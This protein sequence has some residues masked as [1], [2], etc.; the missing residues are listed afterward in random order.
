MPEIKHN[1]TGGKMNK[2]VDQRLVP[3]GEYRDAMNIQVSTSEGSD[4][5]TVQNILGN[6]H[7]CIDGSLDSITNNSTTVG[8]VTDEK[9]DSLYWFISGGQPQPGPN[10]TM[11]DSIWR[12]TSN[13]NCKPVF[14]DNY[15]ISLTNPFDDTF[16]SS[17]LTNITSSVF[18]EIE[19]GWTVVGVTN[20]GV[21]SNTATISSFNTAPYIPFDFGYTPTTN[22][23]NIVSG[24]AVN[25]MID[26]ASGISFVM[27]QDINGN[28]SQSTINEVYLHGWSGGSVNQL[29]GDTI[30]IPAY[31]GNTYTI[32]AASTVSLT[33]LNGLGEQAVKLILDTNTVLFSNPT[34][35]PSV[36]AELTSG[37]GLVGSHNG[38]SISAL[39][40]S[41][42]QVTTNIAN[43]EIIF[44]T[45][46]GVPQTTGGPIQFAY[47]VTNT[48]VGSVVSISGITGGIQLSDFCVQSINTS[49]NS[50]VLEDC[51][52]G[53][54][55][56][57]GF[58]VGGLSYGVPQTTGGS[59]QFAVS[60]LVE[61]DQPLNLQG[62]YQSLYFQGPRTLNFNANTLITGIDVVDGMLFWTDNKT[63]PKKINI[64]RSI[65]GTYS[66]GLQHTRVINSDQGLSIGSNVMAR[67]KHI[68]VIRKSPIKS[69][70]L[71]LSDGRDPSLNYSA[72][73]I[74]SDNPINT[75]IISSSNP[76]TTTDFSGLLIEDTIQVSFPY[77]YDINS[78][79][80]VAWAPGDYLLLKEE[81]NSTDLPST[82]LTN[83]TIRG[84]ILNVQNGNNFDSSNGIVV[85]TIE[86]VGLNGVPPEPAAGQTMMFVADLE[87]SDTRIFQDK[88]PRFSYR[89]KYIDGEYSTFAPWSEPAFIPTSF[90]YDPKKGWNTGM[91]NNL[92]SVKLKGFNTSTYADITSI[93]IL[94]K[95]DS[96]PNVYLVQTI[97]PIDIISS[98]Q[99]DRPWFLNEYIVNSENIK[100]VIP[101]GQLLRAWDG[102]P[103]KAL[104]QSISG[105]RV[106]YGNYEQ[107][108]DLLIG[109]EI[110]TPDFNNSLVAWAPSTAGSPQKSIKSLRDYKLG[111]VFTDKYGR[112]TPVLIGENG[113]FSVKKIE[114]KNYNRLT[115]SLSG[116]PPSEMAYY[117]FYIKETSS[118][119]YNVPMDRWYSAEDGN[120]WLSMPSADRNKIDLDTFL[121]FKKGESGDKNVIENST[122]YK[123]LDIDN[124]APKWIKT[125]KI[126]IGSAKH[127][128][129]ANSCLFGFANDTTNLAPKVGEISF[130]LNYDGPSEFANLPFKTSTL[131]SLQNVEEQLYIQ[132]V[133]G[134]DY[135]SQ[136]AINEITSDFDASLTAVSNYFISLT[137][138]LDN[139]IN[140]IFDNPAFSSAIK[141]DVRVVFTK[142]VI[143]NT[144]NFDGR[145]F[146]K[147][148]NDGKIQSMVSDSTQGINYQVKVSMPVY[149]KSGGDS[150]GDY[151]IH[152]HAYTRSG[153]NYVAKDWCGSV[154]G[155][156]GNFTWGGYGVSTSCSQYKGA[157]DNPGGYNYNRLA[158]RKSFTRDLGGETM[159]SLG[160]SGE[161]SASGVFFI[162]TGKRTWKKRNTVGCNDDTL[163]WADNNNMNA[164]SPACNNLDSYSG[165]GAG[166]IDPFPGIHPGG[167]GSYINIGFS[168]IKAPGSSSLRSLFHGG[169]GSGGTGNYHLHDSISS[170]FGVGTTNDSHN[171]PAT[172]TFVEGF[173]AGSKFKWKEDPTETIYTIV[174]Q[175]DCSY[176]VHFAR[177]SDGYCMHGTA[178]IGDPSTYTKNWD[179]KTDKPIVWNPS[180]DSGIFIDGGLHLGD[181]TGSA[182]HVRNVTTDGG[183]TLTLADASGIQVGMA[184]RHANIPLECNVV[185]VAGNS[186]GISVQSTSSVTGEDLSFG[187]IIRVKGGLINGIDVGGVVGT[188]PQENYLLVD[189]ISTQC[190]NGNS[191]KPMYDLHVGMAL[192]FCNGTLSDN[193][194]GLAI[195]SIGEKDSN[196]N[197]R[198]DLGGMYKP[199]IG[200]EVCP[201]FSS[202]SG[203]ELNKA[204]AVKQAV[205][206]GAS[207]FSEANTDYSLQNHPMAIENGL[208]GSIVAV[209]YTLQFLQEY[210]TYSDGNVMPENPFIW[211][212]KPKNDE[213]VDVYYE[214]S[215]RYSIE[216]N[217]STISQTIPLQS[218]VASVLNEGGMDLMQPLVI[219]VGGP[220]GDEITIQTSIINGIPGAWVGPGSSPTGVNPIVV[221]S[222]LIITKPN[223]ESF[224]VVVEEIMNQTAFGTGYLSNKFRLQKNLYGSEHTLNWHNCYSFGNGVESNRSK[225]VYNASFM[226]NGVKVSSVFEEYAKE[227]RYSGLVYS[228]IYN[229]T[230]GI[231]NLNQFSYAEKITKDIN[232]IYGSI[233]KLHSG[234]GQGGDLVT[235][236]EDR[237]LKI[238]ANKDALF[239]ADGNTNVTSTNNV[240]GQAIPYS[241]EYGISKNPES[242]ASE[243]Y[244]IYFTDKVRGTVMRLSMDGL[245]P[246]SNH[247][248]K[249]WFRDRL[250]LGDKLIGSYDDR[251][252]EYNI[253]IKG[254]TIAKTVTFKEDVK[255]WVSFK[256]FTPENAISC[257]NEYYTFKDGNIWKHH[258]E[259]V[260]RNT[261]YNESLVPSSV[262][263]IFNEV[264]G[265]VKSFKTVNYEG[266]QAK[267]TSKD[268]NNLT[269]MDG[270]YF[271][272]VEEK[273]WHVTNVIT[274][275]EQGGITEFIKKEGKWFGYVTGNDVTISSAGNISGNYDTEDSSI[276]GIGRTSNTTTSIVY[277]CMDDTM[278]NYNDAVTND[279]GSCINF[280]HGCMDPDA[281]NFQL[282]ANTDDGSCY[283]LG[284]TTGPLADQEQFGGS[285]NYD[286]NA[287]VDDG[288]CIAAIWG[289]TILGYFNSNP[290][291]NMP[292]NYC[293]PINLGCTDSSA[294]NYVALVDEMTDVNTDDGSCE[295]LG[296]TDPIATNYNFTSSSPIVDG[297][298][299]NLTYLNGT[300][301]DDGSCTYIGGCTDALACNFDATATQ[302]NGL[303]YFCADD[304]ADNYDAVVPF[305]DYTCLGACTYCN[306]VASVTITNQTTSDAGMSNGTVTIEWPASTSSSVTSYEV[307]NWNYTI[308]ETITSSGNPTETLTITGLEAGTYNIY[309]KTICTTSAGNTLTAG[310]HLPGGNIGTG[311]HFGTTVSTTI[312]STPIPGC[313]DG[314]GANNNVGGTWGAC[315]YD[316]SATV[317]DGSCEYT[318][319]TGCND[320]AYVEY[321]GDCWDAVNQVNGPEGSNYGPWVADTIPTSCLTPI[322]YGCTDSTAF[323]YD[324]N[325]TTDDGSCVAIVLGCTDDTLNNDGSYAASN[326]NVLANTDDGS[327]NPYNC[328]YDLNI[329][330][331]SNGASF[332]FKVLNFTTPYSFADITRTATI[333]GTTIPSFTSNSNVYQGTDNIG[334]RF[335]E[336]IAGYI[337]AGDTSITV[338]FNVT[339]TDG[340]CNVDATTK[341]FTIGC[342]DATADN[343]GSFDITDNTQCT[344][345]GCMDATACN[346]NVLATTSNPGDPCLF[347]GDVNALNYDGASCNAGCVYSGCTD[348][349]PS[350]MNSLVLAASNFDPNTTVS[351]GT[352]NDN[353]CCTYHDDQ[354]VVANLIGSTNFWM[355]RVAYE[356]GSTGYTEAVMSSYVL[357]QSPGL[358]L[359]MT[360]QFPVSNM[361]SSL[362]DR[363]ATILIPSVWESY[364][365]NNNLRVTLSADFNGAC[366]ND[367]LSDQLPTGSTGFRTFNF[368]V[369]C[370]DDNTAINYDP[371]VDLGMASTCIAANPGCMDSTATNYDADFNQDCTELGS[372]NPNDCCC[373]T[374]D[375]PS[376]DATNPVV[377]NT[378][379]SL[380]SPTHA[381]QITFNF[382]AVNTAVSYNIV[383]KL[384]ASST[385]VGYGVVPTSINNGIA[386]Y[387][388]NS[389][390]PAGSPWFQDGTT[391]AFAVL[392]NCEN[393]DGDSCGTAGSGYISVELNSNI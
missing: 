6:Q 187:F 257:A 207:N 41:S 211:E 32:N 206:N 287:T 169:Y 334:R 360:N 204:L 186:V 181:A 140:I 228:G 301:I 341:I 148:E 48:T 83:W 325:A 279:D 329:S 180:S 277:G 209:G 97:S 254:N 125:K 16:N 131:A 311:P 168:G 146:V 149:E 309:V 383:I 213:G 371:S 21:Y 233:Q 199:L 316:A 345:S 281:D 289:C 132:F 20:D 194:Y 130:S 318:T 104:A 127:N 8:S 137:K 362:G 274:N 344:Y 24:V 315:N 349:T 331:S 237:V 55:A 389:P 248:M 217:P 143:Q 348:T 22:T 293:I 307:Y 72:I 49:N 205:M 147:I 184:V 200:F 375:A 335:F 292:S 291:A 120:I 357:G 232:P 286:S 260:D 103:K 312:T 98:G 73:T 253:T 172:K 338:D 121:Y 110:Y 86:I 76:A 385:F 246:I 346:Y 191:L 36:T 182:D 365:Y 214:I 366:D 314:T 112:E 244:R 96:S 370:K 15:G 196:G 154:T 87:Y 262:E 223:G 249:D 339:T 222:T 210:D 141:E 347:C 263:V 47:D 118:E 29:V 94:Y 38:S 340:N 285:I 332:V 102:V 306:D 109:G 337:T 355:V 372:T 11:R 34:L 374:C 156:C 288:S 258:N 115:A 33:Y 343:Y 167:G 275:L 303:C 40:T 378:W 113:G 152:A 95:D 77:D 256:S 70:S 56:L 160:G 75:S 202:T 170:F 164:F 240:L 25:P 65:D 299:G 134:N 106:I 297:P 197:Y 30:E 82:P 92:Q 212:T 216:L 252:D 321:C 176:D 267:V 350:T 392:A 123:V 295:Y 59:I 183:L 328:P 326:Y 234:W 99:V 393:E 308:L 105:N 177:H 269:L 31:S 388:Y 116:V 387:V 327:C 108:Y 57:Q 319:C 100:G 117:K 333:N 218:R 266:S 305:T 250:K 28:F 27:S 81:I 60:G 85:A 74:T 26:V 90:N 163:A 239:N 227:R 354:D 242:F 91:R 9:T 1:F 219:N 129:A 247:G 300:A 179:F 80:S 245:T 259:D 138:P 323:N 14:V 198:I 381:T 12:H 63:E 39:I 364:V 135:S 190:S 208:C 158:S 278:F 133:M 54:T 229:S 128:V 342:T 171:D 185:T 226:G 358:T 139:D 174:D 320:N 64:E 53:V 220:G 391:Y 142:G 107:H 294:N 272:L 384:G 324:A 89:Y 390:F 69:L 241:G 230:S 114:S 52:T 298:N 304:N 159:N 124:E 255:G 166:W 261:F 23:V 10:V 221:G 111:V 93:D 145:F 188:N 7:G 66:N 50:I 58:Q 386:S 373:Y 268:E 162:N 67:E 71:E 243:A 352:N 225:D 17:I 251:K 351:C 136:Y 271:N 380:T 330:I 270:E 19:V 280:S 126:R 62:T 119:Y 144:P 282:S 322:V 175:T 4:V 37:I 153:T 356:P 336:S 203:V 376:W 45:V 193:F 235:L 84:K 3:K 238:L 377:V 173:V 178:F 150:I 363:L 122:E 290:L 265:S 43:G 368:S 5:G 68:T 201:N 361:T 264:P 302:D 382:A 61:L 367:F 101:S 310:E 317:D 2:D 78:T 231:N 284:C 13:D 189:R 224:N 35:D 165:C 18:N 273:G 276:Q 42:D 157:L 236:C 155:G 161:G 313:T 46:Y 192:D 79:F 151:G 353:E 51:Q 88:F 44:N 296:C 359:S 369:G 379:N 215:D 195:K 283:Y